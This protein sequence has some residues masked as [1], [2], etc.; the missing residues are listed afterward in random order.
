[1]ATTYK[2]V[3]GDTLWDIVQKPQYSKLIAGNT[4]QAKIKT[5]A[6][7]NNLKDPDYIVIGQTLTLSGSKATTA[8]AN[9]NVPVINV[10]GPRS[11]DKSGVYR[12][13]YAGWTWSGGSV[14][15]FQVKWT[16]KTAEG[17]WFTGNDSSVG[18]DKAS[19]Y[20]APTEAVEVRLRVRAEYNTKDS[21]SDWSATK[22]HVFVDAPPA[23]PEPNVVI[24]GKKLT[25]TINDADGDLG[26]TIAVFEVW[27]DNTSRW[28]TSGDIEINTG[29]ASWI[30]PGYIVQGSTYKVRCKIVKVVNGTRVESEWSNYSQSL[31]SAPKKPSITALVA[32]ATDHVYI[33]WS[34]ALVNDTSLKVTY[35]IQY[36]ATDPSLFDTSDEPNSITGIEG[37]ARNI[38]ELTT[39]VA[40]FFR[41]RGISAGEGETSGGGESEWSNIKSIKIGEVPSAP[42]TW[43]SAN[44]AIVGEPIH[45]YWIHNSKDGSSET[46]ARI[47][48]KRPG[49]T[50]SYIFKTIQNTATGDQKDATKS[51]EYPT[52][53]F[54]EG[55]EV[56]WSVCTGGVTCDGE[57]QAT[58]GL[59]SETR[60]FKVYVRPDLKVIINDGLTNLEFDGTYDYP[61]L[62]CLPITVFAKNSV[63]DTIQKPIGYT[64]Q[65]ISNMYHETVNHR[66]ED[67]IVGEGDVVYS[68]YFDIDTPLRVELN[69]LDLANGV[70]YTLRCT[71]AMDSGIISEAEY[72]FF[73]DFSERTVDVGAAI[74]LDRDAYRATIYPSARNKQ[75]DRVPEVVFSIFRREYDGGMT[76]IATGI[77]ND[78]THAVTD[79]H[80]SLD[81]TRYRI[82][83]TDP[84]TSAVYCADV[85]GPE[86]KDKPLIIQWDENWKTYETSD[87]TS[88]E[89]A[90]SGSMLKLPYNID[91]SDSRQ[92]E[93]ALIKYIGR[94]HPVAY[95][96]TQ[97]NE[98]SNSSVTI[99]AEDQ[100]TIFMLRR[101]SRW[102]GNV[103][104]R[105]PYG[106]GYWANVRV[107]FSQKHRE[108]AIPVTLDITRVE[109]GA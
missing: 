31:A 60:S 23:P 75:G 100:D 84:A 58:F 66:G 64:I 87:D 52:D 51:C 6:K 62:K 45:L 26:G 18:T 56:Q 71:M 80:P 109:G 4:I 55:A 16:Y 101:L 78:Q 67:I 9:N 106:A 2:V 27:R 85:T 83:A 81:V 86:F 93:V 50:H 12:E 70:D 88:Q 42:T 108:V 40:Y 47:R 32:K 1:M 96:G 98:S 13:M 72:R 59:Y 30:A 24:D 38:T 105:D 29:Y 5:V 61:L 8:T 49:D 22:V 33:E 35:E 76:E 21:Y 39:G 15:G 74:I 103:Y 90:W 43:S 79:P 94:E 19:I 28:K 97:M 3:K 102:K 48:H 53:E 7:L 104:V 14:K 92:P 63:E 77:R 89:P 37:N 91:I 57:K 41:V 82:V 95:Y 44:T 25:A 17:L 10:F 54:T 46:Y 65:I 107:S 11:S 34:S 68:E 36:V 69:N 99:D 20:T 73:T